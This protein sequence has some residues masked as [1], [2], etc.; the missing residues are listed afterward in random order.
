MMQFL[1]PNRDNL[2]T[3]LSIG[4]PLIAFSFIDF[5]ANTFLNQI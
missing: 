5:F 2:N 4:I 3:S 1:K